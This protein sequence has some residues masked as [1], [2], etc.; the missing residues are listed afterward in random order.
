MTRPIKVS[1]PMDCSLEDVL[2][3]AGIG[4]TGGLRRLEHITPE[5]RPQE[6]TVPRLPSAMSKVVR[7]AGDV[8]QG[9]HSQQPL[10][11]LGGLVLQEEGGARPAPAPS[12]L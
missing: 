11:S 9:K 4:H 12:L 10:C 6:V 5:G 3:A 1:H 8:T 7:M 2:R